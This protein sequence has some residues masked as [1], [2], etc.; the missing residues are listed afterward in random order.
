MFEVAQPAS[1]FGAMPEGPDSVE[2]EDASSLT[3]VL[4]R[5]AKTSNVAVQ[6]S[7]VGLGQ[8]VMRGPVL[9]ARATLS[10]WLYFGTADDVAHAIAEL[11]L[12]GPTSIVDLSHARARLRLTGPGAASWLQQRSAIDFDND[13]FPNQRVTVVQIA[14][15]RCEVIRADQGSQRSFIVAFDRTLARWMID[16]AGSASP[17]EPAIHVGAM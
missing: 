5:G 1:P 17:G 14:T 15:V 2:I 16:L 4:L 10:E 8:T 9:I 3:M 13:S 11:D 6:L 12:A 7:G